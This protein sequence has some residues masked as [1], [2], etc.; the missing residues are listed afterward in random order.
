MTPYL[1]TLLACLLHGVSEFLYKVAHDGEL[2]EGTYLCV[3]SGVVFCTLGLISAG[4][5]GWQLTPATVGLGVGCGMVAFATGIMLLISMGR[6]PASVT[7]AVRRLGFIVTGVLAVVFLGEQLTPGKL[8][9]I[10]LAAGGLL[11]MTWAT[12]ES[13][14]PYPLIYVAALTSGVL[15]FGHKLGAMAGVSPSA[16]LMLQAGTVHVG[17]HLWCHW[18]GGYRLRQAGVRLAPLTGVTIAAA[19]TIFLFALR[20]GEAI[21]LVPLVQLSFVVTAVL[22]FLLLREP[23]LP[24]KLIG[25]GLGAAAVLAFGLVA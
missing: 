10:G 13:H 19:M 6:G 4:G 22:S 23:A 18:T 5:V 9:G 24:G 11:T 16:F 25:L 8:A 7:S 3:Q 14:R 15:A 1:L 20:A 21:V 12:H 2:H 17:A